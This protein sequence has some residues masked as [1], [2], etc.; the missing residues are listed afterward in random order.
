MGTTAGRRFPVRE[1]GPSRHRAMPP[2]Y[3]GRSSPGARGRPADRVRPRPAA[4]GSS[5][6]GYI[7]FSVRRAGPPG[8]SVRLTIDSPKSRAMLRHRSG[9][10]PAYEWKKVEGAAAVVCTWAAGAC[11]AAAT[12][13]PAAPSAMS[14][15]MM[16]ARPVRMIPP[17]RIPRPAARSRAWPTR[18]A[19][20]ASCG[21]NSQ[22]AVLLCVMSSHFIP[23]LQY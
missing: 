13:D 5:P 4:A 11:P 3:R 15:E 16:I 14:A 1:P 7:A 22:P 10:G 21:V 9:V 19:F 20:S 2:G 23:L 6:G 12:I 17:W 18:L 8:T